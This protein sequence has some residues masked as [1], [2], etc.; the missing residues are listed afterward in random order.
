MRMTNVLEQ[1]RLARERAIDGLVAQACAKGGCEDRLY[2]TLVWD[3]E[4]APITTNMKQL[5]E[6]GHIPASPSQLDSASL[7]KA[8]RELS[9]RLASLGIFMMRTD[10]LPDF[11]FYDR[12]MR[13]VLVEEVRDLPPSEGVVEWI[14][15][16]AGELSEDLES[17]AD[18]VQRDASLPTPDH[19]RWRVQK[20]DSKK[21]C[22]SA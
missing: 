22:K 16:G 19:P 13:H 3:L 18:G 9:E 4:M 2:W 11:E 8:I 17:A 1:K 12:L 7:P 5:E 14:D 6:I 10:H 15:L 20:G 21:M